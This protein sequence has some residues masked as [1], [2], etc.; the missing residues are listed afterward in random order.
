MEVILI[1]QPISSVEVEPTVPQNICPNRKGMFS[2]WEPHIKETFMRQVENSSSQR[3]RNLLQRFHSD[4]FLIAD[5]LTTEADEPKSVSE[6]L[7]GEH[8]TQ[9]GEVLNSEYSSLID[10]GTWE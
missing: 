6:A 4:G 8:F 5:S 10:N 2:Q 3:R 7:N 1:E 9:W